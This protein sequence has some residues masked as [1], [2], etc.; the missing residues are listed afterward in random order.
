[1]SSSLI[2]TGVHMSSARLGVNFPSQ[3][4]I[5]R[6]LL[7]SDSE[8]GELMSTIA[9]VFSGSALMPRTSMTWPRN[10]SLVFENSHFCGLNITLASSMRLRTDSRC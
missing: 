7:N 8:V 1:M 4:A 6:N 2:L 9:L 5:P 10:V 3:L